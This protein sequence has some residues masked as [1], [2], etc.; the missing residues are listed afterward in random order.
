MSNIEYFK[1]ELEKTKQELPGMSN[2]DLIDNLI[3]AHK[4]YESYLYREDGIHWSQ[5]T[6]DLVGQIYYT[7]REEILNRMDRDSEE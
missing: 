2:E 3:Y 7:I 5:E 4:D 1:K 6:E